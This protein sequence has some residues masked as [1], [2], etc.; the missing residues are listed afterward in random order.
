MINGL[1]AGRPLMEYT[2]ATAVGSSDDAPR[3]YTVSVGKATVRDAFKW[4]AAVS[5][6]W[7]NAGG[8]VNVGDCRGLDDDDEPRMIWSC[9]RQGSMGVADAI[10]DDCLP[11]DGVIIRLKCR[12]V[13]RACI[14]ANIGILGM[15]ICSPTQNLLCLSPQVLRVW[16]P[17][18]RKMERIERQERFE[19]SSQFKIQINTDKYLEGFKRDLQSDIAW[20]NNACYTL[21]SILSL[22]MA[23][24]VPPINF[25]LVEDGKLFDPEQ[26]Q[27]DNQDSTA[28][29][30]LPSSTSLSSRN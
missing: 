15:K 19:T 16:S 3:P 30:N 7:R 2:L 20:S 24:I 23:K 29:H 17:D 25:G 5:R 22:T 28:Q 14:L 21:P 26:S 6:C 10:V 12:V 11:G 27:A 8:M 13:S 9:S 18:A 1:S 4:A